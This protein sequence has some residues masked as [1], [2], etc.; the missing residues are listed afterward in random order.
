VDAAYIGSDEDAGSAIGLDGE[1]RGGTGGA[2]RGVGT[3]ARVGGAAGLTLTC[4]RALGAFR[5]HRPR[6]IVIRHRKCPS[7]G[8]G[9][10]GVS[11]QDRSEKMRA[12]MAS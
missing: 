8:Q 7:G 11:S 3:V 5:P 1:H 4:S 9:H 12:E 6:D 10:W 2:A